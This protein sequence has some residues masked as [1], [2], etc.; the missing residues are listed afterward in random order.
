[1]RCKC[2]SLELTN[3]LSVRV[4]VG[5]QCQRIEPCGRDLGT[6]SS[7]Q[8]F[9]L[10]LE[11]FDPFFERGALVPRYLDAL[12]MSPRLTSSGTFSPVVER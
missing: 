4:P 12:Q 6:R 8:T 1:M 9:P 10:D 3:G 5:S 7:E 11:V 2:G